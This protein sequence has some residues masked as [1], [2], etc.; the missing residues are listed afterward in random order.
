[1]YFIALIHGSIENMVLIIMFEIVIYN[2]ITIISDYMQDGNPNLLLN[3]LIY[4]CCW[5]SII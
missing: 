5:F 1:M 3:V 2:I 4:I